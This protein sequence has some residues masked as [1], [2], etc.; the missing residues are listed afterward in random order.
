MP[1]DTKKCVSEF[2]VAIKEIN[3]FQQVVMDRNDSLQKKPQ[4]K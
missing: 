1:N 3:F 4:S 2:E